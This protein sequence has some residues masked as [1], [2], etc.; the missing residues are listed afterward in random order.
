MALL[1]HRPI[2]SWRAGDSVQGFAFLRRKELRQDKGGRDYLDVELADASGS[3]VGKAWSDSPAL[4]AQFSAPGFVKFRG[5]V[6]SY[7]DQLQL[8]LDQCRA[9]GPA[10][11]AEGFDEA[12]LVPTTRI[13]LADLW[14]ALEETLAG[15]VARPELRRLAEE[16]LAVHGARLKVHPAAKSIHHAV[17]GGLLEHVV[18]MLGLAVKIADHYPELDRDLLLLGVLL[19]DLGKIE[20]L[21]AMPYNDY[22]PVGR[23]VGHVVIGRDLLRERIAAIP[24]FP[25]ALALALEHLV[26]SHQGRKEFASPVEPMTREALALH[27]IDDLDSKL[28]VVRALA[29]GGAG[30]VWARSLDRFVYL[31][32]D[33]A[34]EAPAAE[35]PLEAPPPADQKS[36]W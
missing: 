24:G 31:G 2:A 30:F 7:R 35:S 13:P 16:T 33:G 11:A 25:P 22:T 26:L 4:T 12:A 17:R 34:G 14:R 32:E 5:Q 27:M 1:S 28:A 8:K 9:A 18:S 3:I 20:E 15:H 29:E 10:D 23:L 19:H 36:I 6:Q 21:G